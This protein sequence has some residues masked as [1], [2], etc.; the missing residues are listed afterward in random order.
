MFIYSNPGDPIDLTKEEESLA[1]G[2]PRAKEERLVRE[3]GLLGEVVE[4]R[5][6]LDKI[7]SSY[8]PVTLS[9]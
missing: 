1:L 6:H 9:V 2:R 8:E 4:G 7:I 5:V 3:I